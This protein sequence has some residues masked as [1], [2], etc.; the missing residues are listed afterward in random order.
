MSSKPEPIRIGEENMTPE[1]RRDMERIRKQKEKAR[2]WESRV[3]A[4]KAHCLECSGGK[5]SYVH[6]CPSVDCSLWPFRV[7][8]PGKSSR[9]S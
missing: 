1:H 6:T 7:G 8:S 9:L 3:E 4:V 5:W 2:E